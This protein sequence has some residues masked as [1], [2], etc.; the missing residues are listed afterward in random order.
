MCSMKVVSSYPYVKGKVCKRCFQ[1]R[2][3]STK[4]QV[5]SGC[6]RALDYPAEQGCAVS[7][8]STRTVSCCLLLLGNLMLNP[9]P[10]LGQNTFHCLN[11]EMFFCVIRSLESVVWKKE[12]GTSG[13]AGRLSGNIQP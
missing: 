7:C 12:G 9:V 1:G 8:R 10:L 5:G 11:V 6:R 4:F 2:Q 13:A 3:E